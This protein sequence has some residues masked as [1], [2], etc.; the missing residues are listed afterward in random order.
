MQTGMKSKVVEVLHKIFAF[1]SAS[2]FPGGQLPTAKD[3]I[4][5][6]LHEKN[7]SKRITAMYI[8][9]KTHSLLG[10]LQCLYVVPQNCDR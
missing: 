7:W 2:K 3:I 5:R 10:L 6:M 8:H 1:T 9:D 4:E